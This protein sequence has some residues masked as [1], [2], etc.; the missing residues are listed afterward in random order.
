MEQGPELKSPDLC[1][2]QPGFLHLMDEEAYLRADLY[3]CQRLSS[4]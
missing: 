1:I 2:I 3:T 4:W